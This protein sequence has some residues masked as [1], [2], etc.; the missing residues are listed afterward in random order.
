MC[1]RAQRV[2]DAGVSIAMKDNQLAARARAR[3]IALLHVWG[4]FSGVWSEIYGSCAPEFVPDRAVIV[5]IDIIWG[6]LASAA[7][8]GYCKEINAYYE[9]PSAL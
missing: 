2:I 3:L 8:I 7:A 9:H 1:A 4:S 6:Q 5:M